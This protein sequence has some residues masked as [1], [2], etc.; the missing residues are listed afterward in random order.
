[1]FFLVKKIYINIYWL[2][3][4]KEVVLI[5]NYFEY[6]YWVGAFGVYYFKVY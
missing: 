5:E 4:E 2:F 1:M 6:M 3:K